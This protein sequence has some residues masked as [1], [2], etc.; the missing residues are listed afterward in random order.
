M[1]I[2]ALLTMA[3]AAR[4]QSGSY[5][6]SGVPLLHAT[7]PGV[8]RAYVAV[9]SPRLMKINCLRI[10]LQ[11]PGLELHSTGRINDW[12]DGVRE[13][14][15]KRT[16]D[17]ISESRSTARPIVAAINAQPWTA[18]DNSRSV[19]VN[20]VYGLT[21]S[22]G[23]LVSS[24]ETYNAPSFVVNQDGTAEIIVKRAADNH[25]ISQI[26]TA[27]SGFGRVLDNGTLSGNNVDLAQRTGIGL[28]QDCRYAYFMTVDGK[29]NQWS[30][31][32]T[33]YE[34][35]EWLR[36]FGA[37]TG[38]NMDGG[39]ST[40]M[41]WWDP[42]GSG[43]SKL[44]NVPRDSVASSGNP[45][46]A[47]ERYVGNNIGVFYNNNTY[48]VAYDANGATG[49]TA[50]AAQTK[51]HDI[52]LTLATNSGNLA[53]TGYAY[54]G[55]NTAT[56]GSGTDYAAGG[57][58]TANAAATLYANW[59][60]A[61]SAA[62]Y[63]ANN[64][65]TANDWG[66][67]ANWST[68]VGGGTTPGAIPGT[69]DVATF[70][71]TPIQ[72]TAQ[73]VNING[74]PSVLGLNVFSGVTAN[75]I[76]QGGGV[77][78]TLTNGVSGIVNNSS[79][80]LTIGSGTANQNV[81]LTLAGSQSISANGSGGVAIL[82]N[83]SGTGS[84]T[85][86]NSG[87]G[88]GYVGMGTLQS[89]VGKIVQNSVTST[90]GLRA[91]NSAFNGNIEILKGTL[92]IGT[93][94]NNLGNATSGQVI[95]GGSGSDAA[96]LDINDN[97]SQT[98]VAKPIALGT[99]SGTLTIR[100]RDDTG[101]QTHTITGPV[102]GTNNLTIENQA[103][104]SENNDKL[105]FTTGAINNA[106]TITHIGDGSG[107][108][109]ISAVIGSNVT[110][111]I[112]NSATSRMVLTGANTY[113]GDTVVSAG[114][115]SVDGGAI[116]DSGKL[117]IH[118]GGQVSIAS[119]TE[120]VG[121]LFFGG[122]QQ[123]AG[124]W[125]STASAATHRTNT[126]FTG[127]GM[128]SVNT[129]PAG[130]ATYTVT[131]DGN[132]KESGSAPVDGTS[133]S[134]N[135]TVTV[136]GNTGN[137]AKSG[138]SF[139][140]WNTV[141]NGSGTGYAPA[142]TFNIS[143][144]TT[145][146]AQWTPV[147]YGSHYWDNAGGAANDW[148][149][150]ANWS[151]TAG[152][153]T[154]PPAIPG[155]SDVALFSA[156]P[157]Q[158]APQTVNLNGDRSVLGLNVLS[159][160]T[161]NTILQGGGTDRTLTIGNSGIAKNGGFALTLGS[162]TAGQRVHLTLA[163]SQSIANNSSGNITINNNVGGTGSPALTNNGSGSGYVGMG[164]LQATVGR[165]VQDSATSTLGL[166]ANNSA[167]NGNVEIR[168]GTVSIGTSSN[169][170]GNAASGQVILGGSGSDAATLEINDNSS[171]TYVAKPIMLG[172][173][174]GLLKIVLR[175]DTGVNTHTLTGPISGNNSL[176]LENQ[177][178][179]DKLTFNSGGLNNAGT[180]THIGD[181][182]GDLT[183]SAVIGSNVTGLIQSSATSKMVLT[184]ANTYAGNTTITAGTLKLGA[185]GSI[186]NT[187][188]ISIAAGATY[189]V[190]AITSY[191][192][193]GSTALSAAGMGA[194]PGTT[195]ADIKGATTV[196][197]GSQALELTFTPTTLWRGDTNHPALLISQGTLKLNNNA[198][199][200]NNAS[201]APLGTG[202]YRLIEVTDGAIAGTPNAAV[203]VT[204]S[205]IIGGT[206]SLSVSGGYVNL[207]IPHLGTVLSFR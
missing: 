50:P 69:G 190:S 93:S 174:S 29:A 182:S 91:N 90:L 33:Q 111:V 84:P 11:T 67:L 47:Q 112:Q 144:N 178:G 171:Q 156:T 106:G 12:E 206:P 70:S 185:A 155:T 157:I 98:Y 102:S 38:I 202:T 26:R 180:I 45:P 32:A 132:G 168:K 135:A 56:N 103:N 163:G 128:I 88:T 149:G 55:W 16:R 127:T 198:I 51:T 34:V 116:P 31:G 39:G 71:A 187:P 78:R 203:T 30:L 81:T 100:L 160:V 54:S 4:A 9:T 169:N 77:N 37:H 186:S 36:H 80:S 121:T 82:N 142:S 179:D 164:A 96:T 83:V 205:G 63:W 110:G 172:T 25:D 191:T 105:T 125:G 145:L 167:Y 62:I 87:A 154:T 35:G 188:R 136:L 161:A 122:V 200:I 23:V 134:S 176:T 143:S 146:Y 195:A 117:V 108:L 79:A 99:T 42:A 64:G 7:Y 49:G 94:P 74:N 3:T 129:G 8:Q 175:D 60:V 194:G 24:F 124:T 119:G 40:T 27:V 162:G 17:F 114:T 166:R 109:T 13:T 21:V 199:T 107:D 193:S 189:D 66:S 15:T 153:G 204:G 75:T 52:Q 133:Y 43:S 6:W 68:T 101:T 28:S 73:T 173:A 48:P 181:G 148:G 89:T 170:L 196:D 183:I 1:T 76:L 95:L 123:A 152:G 207:I 92:S 19:P 46:S 138:Y 20:L 53:K 57:T 59:T 97:S 41:A 120:T 14:L 44:L 10:D 61:G 18:V 150:A 158:G 141:T 86:T 2:M 137:L 147:S 130:P 159:G 22:E 113:G 177:G 140:G 126:Y 139:A 104:G 115:L 118:S 5:D 65:G 184:K 72:G 201:G 85:L 131:Y 58:Y 151:T 165:V 197:L 192:L